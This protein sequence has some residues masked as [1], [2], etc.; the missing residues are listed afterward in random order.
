MSLHHR[1]IWNIPWETREQE[2]KHILNIS[3]ITPWNTGDR[4]NPQ[5]AISFVSNGWG[6]RTSDKHVTENRGLFHLLPGDVILADRGFL[7]GT[8]I[9]QYN[10]KL[11]IPAF[12]K[13]RKQLDPMEIEATRGL[14]AVKIHVERVITHVRQK[15]C[16][17]MGPSPS[18]C[19]SV[20]MVKKK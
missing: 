3:S 4:N 11:Q 1:L 12:I 16:I 8:S 13:F 18:V 19:V 2:H 5:G 7:V 15:Y 9:R 6:G 14:A 20:M 17:L 10:A